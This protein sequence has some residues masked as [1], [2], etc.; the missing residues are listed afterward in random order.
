MWILY[1]HCKYFKRISQNSGM[2][3][4]KG[5]EDM[6]T[7]TLETLENFKYLSD[8]KVHN[9]DLYYVETTM[10]ME[11]N[12]YKQ[13]L[14]KYNTLTKEDSIYIDYKNRSTT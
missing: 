5:D 8:L 1:E 3:T 2:I 11:N 7:I 13:C 10:D 9:H 12:N 6:K 4:N 14:H